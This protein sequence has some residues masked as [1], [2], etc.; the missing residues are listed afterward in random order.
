MGQ[1]KRPSG[2]VTLKDK[3]DIMASRLTVHDV[4]ARLF[5]PAIFE[6]SGLLSLA[7]VALCGDTSALQT[8]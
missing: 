5:S 7:A 1:S 4:P 3:F 6:V 2:A 8:G